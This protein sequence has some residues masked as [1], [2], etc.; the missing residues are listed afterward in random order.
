LIQDRPIQLQRQKPEKPQ[1]YSQSLPTS[2]LKCY[3]SKYLNNVQ[4][5]PSRMIE[6]K[7]ILSKYCESIKSSEL[8]WHLRKHS[9]RSTDPWSTKSLLHHHHY[10]MYSPTSITLFYPPYTRA[11]TSNLD[12]T[13][14]STPTDPEEKNKFY[15]TFTPLNTATHGVP[16]GNTH[17]APLHIRPQFEP[18]RALHQP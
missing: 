5:Q 8:R 13:S 10:Y 4:P 17:N 15:F 3:R 6:L 16:K 7:H 18:I 11:S 12:A 1:S 9:P 14:T 2:T